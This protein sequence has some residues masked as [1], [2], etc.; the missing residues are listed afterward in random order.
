MWETLINNFLIFP[1]LFLE[2]YLSCYVQ[3]I[4]SYGMWITGKKYKWKQIAACI[5]EG[6]LSFLLSIRKLIGIGILSFKQVNIGTPIAARPFI[7]SQYLFSRY[8]M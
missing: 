7:Q 1:R 6:F 8:S 3:S 4:V 5:L 2:M